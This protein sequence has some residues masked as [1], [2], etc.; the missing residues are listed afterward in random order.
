M[1][2]G[3]IGSTLLAGC[4]STD[5]GDHCRFYPNDDALCVC[6]EYDVAWFRVGF[7]DEYG[8]Q[9]TIYFRSDLEMLGLTY[10]EFIYWSETAGMYF[11]D[12]G[13]ECVEA[14]KKTIWDFLKL[15]VDRY[16]NQ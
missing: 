2:L 10:S 3:L 13:W 14:R 5:S 1:I 11:I 4:N 8:F 15:M 16:D 6:L 12:D 9:E 7:V